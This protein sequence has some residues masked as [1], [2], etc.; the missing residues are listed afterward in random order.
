MN[1]C[2]GG[3]LGLGE[4]HQDRL[5][6]LQSLANLPQHPLSVPINHLT[7]FEGTPLAKAEKVEPFEFVR[8]I[9]CARIL[10]PKSYVRFACGRKDMSDELHALCFLAGA[11]SI[12][13]GE[14]LLMSKN[15]E[16]DRDQE[17]LKRLNINT[18]NELSLPA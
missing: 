7:A 5:S 18:D 6:F 12:F 15:S 1:S 11:N 4:S 17:L 9:A 8:V 13:C 3:I 10:M 14:K 16:Q 2:C